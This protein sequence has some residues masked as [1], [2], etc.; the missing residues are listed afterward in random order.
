MSTTSTPN[1]A[2]RRMSRAAR[3][4]QLIGHAR[5]EFVAS[6]Y[7]NASMDAIAARAGVSKPVLYQHFPGK[8]ELYLSIL[9]DA[10]VGLQK[11]LAESLHRS[12]DLET[13]VHHT[14]TT[15]FT[16][17]VARD[18]GMRLALQ[19]ELS[20]DDDAT[21]RLRDLQN[22]TIDA[23]TK[24]LY[25]VATIPDPPARALAVGVVG[26]AQYA[27][28]TWVLSGANIQDET[29][30]RFAELAWS[31]L[32]GFATT[33]SSDSPD[34]PDT[35]QDTTSTSQGEPSARGQ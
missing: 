34:S 20:N 24:R 8:R 23:V 19:S 27:S 35:Q 22:W 21:A 10:I 15:Y 5:D 17:A 18:S 28:R 9:D 6:G 33:Y 12:D 29:V 14:V 2:P 26:L 4:E 3:R 31:G 25:E 11:I 7:H 1:E 13:L 30:R 16:L 32:Q